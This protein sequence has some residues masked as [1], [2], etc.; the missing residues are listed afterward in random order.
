MGRLWVTFKHNL[1]HEVS[2]EE[3]HTFKGQPAYREPTKYQLIL[4]TEQTVHSV[5]QVSCTVKF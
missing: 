3:Q 5:L 4:N 1:P 2:V